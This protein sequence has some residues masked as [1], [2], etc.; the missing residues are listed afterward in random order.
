MREHERDCRP[1][2]LGERQ[3]LRRKLAHHVAIERYEGDDPATEED[4]KQQQRIIRWLSERLSLFDQQ[5]CPLCSRLGFR[6]PIPFEP[7][8][9][10]EKGQLEARSLRDA[11][12]A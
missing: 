6:R 8:Y 4:R 1:L 9:R 2:L 5:A 7:E 3:E 10:V 12:P 11:A